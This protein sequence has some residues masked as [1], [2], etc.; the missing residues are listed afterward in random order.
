MT[1]REMLEKH[2]LLKCLLMLLTL[3]GSI[4]WV[5]QL[6]SPVMKVVLFIGFAAACYDLI[7]RRMPLK[8]AGLWLLLAFAALYCVTALVNGGGQGSRA[9]RDMLY[10]AMLFIVLYNGQKGTDP[11]LERR[12]RIFLARAAL[13]MML[14]LVTACLAAYMILTP[15]TYVT[16]DGTVGYLGSLDGRLTGLV[17]MNVIGAVSALT[18]IL[19]AGMLVFGARGLWMIVCAAA[20]A[21]STVALLLSR[22]RTSMLALGITA[23][24]TLGRYAVWTR[25]SPEKKSSVR[26]AAISLSCF[27]AGLFIAYIVYK[28]VGGKLSESVQKLISEGDGLLTGRVSIWIEGLKSFASH[29]LLGVTVQN[30]AA[31]AQV[32]IEFDWSGGGIHSLY[33]GVPVGSGLA[34]TA[35]LTAFTVRN[36]VIG[37]KRRR[38]AA[39]DTA[40]RGGYDGSWHLAGIMICFLL[41]EGIAED[42]LLHSLSFFAVVFWLCMGLR[43]AAADI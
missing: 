27:A 26:K 6:I 41:L 14:A 3:F 2:T 8:N 29:P 22:S 7:R 4:A 28:A 23:V 17:H 11:E 24:Y 21:L 9:I 13:V 16:A 15:S 12:E 35:V 5:H 10:M 33:V 36:L 31:T 34:G 40:M 32:P 38:L 42:Y 39:A 19:A 43:K 20:I 25:L 1:F 30:F 37:F 18:I